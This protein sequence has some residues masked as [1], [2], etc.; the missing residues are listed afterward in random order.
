MAT[1]RRIEVG[2][3]PRVRELYRALTAELARRYPEDRIGISEQGVANVE[4]QFRVGPVHQDVLT[5]AE[6]DGELVGLA[7]GEI[8][9]SGYLPCVAG[10]VGVWVLE[11]HEEDASALARA[12]IAWLRERGA[13]TVFHS[14]DVNHHDRALWEALGF[15]LDVMRFSLYD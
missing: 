9:R 13:R 6:V 11:G 8:T 12:A 10:E 3:A 14:D 5:L 4:T 15:E 2:E 1:I 7:T